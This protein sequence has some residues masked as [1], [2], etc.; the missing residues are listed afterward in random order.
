MLF[1]CG[2]YRSRRARALCF[3]CMLLP[4][5]LNS[6]SSRCF[7]SSFCCISTAS[8]VFFICDRL[9]SSCLLLYVS[10]VGFA[11]FFLY[12]LT[13]LYV[14]VFLCVCLSDRVSCS[15][16]CVICLF[17]SWWWSPLPLYINY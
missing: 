7:Y 8:F 14:I 6:A 13:F 5:T 10:S 15:F 2:P 11:F 12:V 16:F 9:R 17:A 1:M 3:Y 4:A